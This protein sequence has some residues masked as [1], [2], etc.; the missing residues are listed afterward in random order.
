MSKAST[1]EIREPRQARSKERVA[2]ILFTARDLIAERGS[3]AVKVQDIADRAGINVGTIYQYFPNKS[4]IVVKLAKGYIDEMRRF[5][6]AVYEER[7]VDI[8][9]AVE[10]GRRFMRHYFD[11]HDKDPAYSEIVLWENVDREIAEL[12]KNDDRQ[13]IEFQLDQ[14]RHLVPASREGDVRRLLAL[15]M[16]FTAAAA[17]SAMQA[18]GEERQKLFTEAIDMVCGAYHQRLHSITGAPR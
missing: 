8:P 1:S 17:R 18:S 3:A 11:T 12:E 4:A 14:I 6:W 7:V 13:Y 16:A 5:L 15:C 10:R 9:D 2:T